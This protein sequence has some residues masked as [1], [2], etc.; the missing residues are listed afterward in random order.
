MKRDGLVAVTISIRKMWRIG[1]YK[2]PGAGMDPM[3]YSGHSLR[4]GFATSAAMAGV[5][6][7]K[8]RKQTRHSTD[9]AVARYIR[10]SMLVGQS[11]VD[12]LL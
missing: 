10:G 11:T 2:A 5:P 7:W 6:I 8:I 12:E 9:Q 3:G 4:A 1:S